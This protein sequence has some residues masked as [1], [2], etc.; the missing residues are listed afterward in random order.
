MELTYFG[1][2][3]YI[4]KMSAK[5][6]DSNIHKT[7]RLKVLKDELVLLRKKSNDVRIPVLPLRFLGHVLI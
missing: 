1:V 5:G 4:S 6:S 3:W 2:S 7:L